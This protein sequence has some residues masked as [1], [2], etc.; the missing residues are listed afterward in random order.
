MPSPRIHACR[1][2]IRFVRGP[3]EAITGIWGLDIGVAIPHGIQAE[4]WT[5]G[6]DYFTIDIW[7]D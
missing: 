7:G 3:N 5:T 1:Y 2:R 6:F 4:V